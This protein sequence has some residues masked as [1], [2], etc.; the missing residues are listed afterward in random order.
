[1]NKTKRCKIISE[2]NLF[3]KFSMDIQP[4]YNIN[5][6]KTIIADRLKIKSTDFNILIS[7]L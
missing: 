6:I 7:I 1:M 5:S 4:N 2:N 3:K